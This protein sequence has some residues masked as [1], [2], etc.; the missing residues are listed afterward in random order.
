MSEIIPARYLFRW[1][2]PVAYCPPQEK[3][4]QP[5]F[6]LP[7]G[8]RLPDLTGLDGQTSFAE[9]SLGW[10]EQGIA[11]STQV[12]GKHHKLQTAPSHL[13]DTDGLSVWIDTRC[14]QNVHRATRYCVQFK[15]MPTGAGTNGRQP[16]ALRLPIA[17]AREDSG[18][19][20]VSGIQLASEPRGDGYRLDAWLPASCLFGFDP[21]NQ[22]RLGFYAAVDDNELGLAP[23]SVG[24]KFPI[25][26]DPSQWLTIELVR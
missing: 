19:Q 1:A 6:P 25:S 12:R 17:M 4:G 26:H 3:S 8:C 11:V 9:F 2:F 23:L 22:P 5:Q 18:E 7:A 10:N 24:D 15:L 14:T 16:Y 21:E 13:P 20:T